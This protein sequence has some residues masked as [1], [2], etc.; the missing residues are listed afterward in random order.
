VRGHYDIGFFS[1]DGT[2]TWSLRGALW[3]PWSNG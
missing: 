1:G 3:L 2:L